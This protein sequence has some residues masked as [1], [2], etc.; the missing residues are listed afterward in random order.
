MKSEK[1]QVS[2]VR[3]RM[4]EVG[5]WEITKTSDIVLQASGIKMGLRSRGSGVR[6]QKTEVRSEKFKV[7]SLK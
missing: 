6:S 5:C 1:S 7:K 3:R 2:G 4:S